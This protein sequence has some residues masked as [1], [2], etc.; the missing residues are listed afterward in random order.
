MYI[1]TVHQIFLLMEKD[2]FSRFKRQGHFKKMLAD[3]GAYKLN[4]K[5]LNLELTKKSR[6]SINELSLIVTS[7]DIAID[8]KFVNDIVEEEEE[9]EMTTDNIGV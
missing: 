9:E 8:S 1:I 3:L 2:T 6:E 7:S 4:E 5:D